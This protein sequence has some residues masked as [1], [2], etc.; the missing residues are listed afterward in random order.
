MWNFVPKKAAYVFEK[1][2]KKKK[3]K[4]LIGP[5]SKHLRNQR[6]SNHITHCSSASEAQRTFVTFHLMLST[7]A[8]IALNLGKDWG[9]YDGVFSVNNSMFDVGWMKNNFRFWA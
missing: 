7:F 5:V 6:K 3:T 4:T 2:T 8:K 9:R 1:K